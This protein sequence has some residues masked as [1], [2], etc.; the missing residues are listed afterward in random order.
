M[1]YGTVVVVYCPP[2]IPCHADHLPFQ[3]RSGGATPPGVFEVLSTLVRAPQQ[4]C[5]VL[6]GWLTVMLGFGE[7]LLNSGC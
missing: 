6:S 4:Q 3:T 2:H 7:S 1:L 5:L